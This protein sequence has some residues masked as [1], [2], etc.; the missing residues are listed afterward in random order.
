MT[1]EQIECYEK[2]LLHI[3]QFASSNTPT[4]RE[5]LKMLQDLATKVGAS[6]HS[7]TTN[8]PC[9]QASVAELAHNIHQALQT[10]SMIDVCRTA[11]RNFEIAIEA[12]RQAR[13]SQWIAV[14]AMM[15][16]VAAA[17]AAWVWN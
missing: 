2:Q 6:T 13:I 3:S 11:E 17:V 16:A 10:L 9:G 4:N 7:I 1:S 8:D 12:Q 15:A 14:A 5:P